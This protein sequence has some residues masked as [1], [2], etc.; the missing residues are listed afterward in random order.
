MEDLG[1]FLQ[2]VAKGTERLPDVIRARRED[3]ANRPFREAQTK[4]AQQQVAANEEENTPEAKAQREEARVLGLRG[5][6][7]EVAK[8]EFEI[9]PEERQRKVL[10]E[11][12]QLELFNLQVTDARQTGLGDPALAETKKQLAQKALV[13]KLFEAQ[14]QIN[15]QTAKDEN[16]F[17][18]MTVKNRLALDAGQ[19]NEQ[20]YRE[21]SLKIGNAHAKMTYDEF[22]ASKPLR[23]KLARF[24][25]RKAGLD[26][27]H[28]VQAILDMQKADARRTDD[29]NFQFKTALLSSFLEQGFRQQNMSI[30]QLHRLDAMRSEFGISMMSSEIA[31]LM[32]TGAKIDF[33]KLNTIVGAS[34]MNKAVNAVLA[35]AVQAG[36]SASNSEAFA[37][38]IAP[39]LKNVD[40]VMSAVSTTHSNL[41]ENGGPGMEMDKVVDALLP[42]LTNL[43]EAANVKFE[44]EA[45][46][47]GLIGPTE[48]PLPGMLPDEAH[49]TFAR[50]T[51]KKDPTPKDLWPHREA[52]IAKVQK[53]TGSKYW[54]WDGDGGKAVT[55]PTYEQINAAVG[56]AVDE[57][58]SGTF[59][60]NKW[61]KRGN[62]RE[63]SVH[64]L[65]QIAKDL[66]DP[67]RSK[68]VIDALWKEAAA[69]D[70]FDASQPVSA[71]AILEALRLAVP[72]LVK[73][74]RRLN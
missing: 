4:L 70:K 1:G 40:Q 54:T 63:T 69:T 27:I 61:D 5:K 51:G 30:E 32:K 25:V 45:E 39:A 23:D 60:T 50:L 59:V 55:V 22:V 57:V 34:E 43:A 46:E 11:S 52:L 14:G 19:I 31:E 29:R 67:K 3:E 68:K 72:I 12:L 21:E 71:N 42:A 64:E 48:S 65:Q 74:N 38:A 8:S 66:T 44:G 16:D 58:S 47:A 37:R 62:S 41:K 33:T 7:A 56:S 15:E 10:M 20:T 28:T 26:N 6:R 17:Y 24:G 18:N 49:N 73:S 2:G 53:V 35:K 13:A 36:G 9:S